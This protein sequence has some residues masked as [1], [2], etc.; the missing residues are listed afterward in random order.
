[1]LDRIQSPDDVKKLDARLLPE[2]CAEIRA[3]LVDHVA[4][5]GGHLASNLGAVELT[6]AVHRVFDTSKDRLVFDVGHQCYIHKMLTGRKDGFASL[7][8]TGGLAG[9][10]KPSESVHDAFIA[11]HA[12]NSISVALGMARAR[13]LEGKDHSVIALIGDGALTGGLAYEAL[14]DAGDSGEKLIVLLNDNG[15]SITEN[16]GGIARH[17]ARQRTRRKY[18][19][20][21]KRY[22]R[23]L[24]AIPGGNWLYRVTHKLKTAAKDA[25]FHCS[26]FEEMGF[27]YV[28]PVDGHDVHK[29]VDAL[30]LAKEFGGPVLVHAITKKGKGYAFSEEYPDEYHGVS[31]FDPKC[32]AGRHNGGD[33]SDVFGRALTG[34]AAGNERIIAV[35][36]A[37]TDGVGLAGFRERFPDRLFD[38][39]IAEAHAAAM[40]AGAA[41][42]GLLPVCAVYSAFLQR[43]YDQLIH[44]TAILGEHVV[45]AVDRAGLVGADGET[46]HGV[47]D[48]AFLRTVP[49]MKL[50]APAS[51]Q[52]LRDMLALAVE[53]LDGPVA[54]RYPRG[55]EGAYRDGGADGSRVL[56]SGR[57]VTI[58]TYGVQVND[59]LAAAEQLEQRQVEAEIVKL[60]FLK[61]LDMEAIRASVAK[62]GRLIVFEETAGGCGVG[63]EIKA[64][65]LDLPSLRWARTLDLGEGFVKHG[66]VQELRAL[67]GLDAAGLVRAVMEELS[68]ER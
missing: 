45:F 32:G 48:V 34:L 41:Q 44:D 66:S 24:R 30:E 67:V 42:E 18:I 46:H 33:F 68:R 43:A 37:M 22:R 19:L 8:K 4:K 14:S 52:E 57:D 54:V 56:R 17:L 40:A 15:M 49:G 10:P 12:S 55:A 27:Q 47:F 38:V 16:V 65:L 60:G 26:M 39:G 50:L 58:V 7:R 5:T 2:L 59:A 21:K 23:L 64:G 62:T 20:F 13:T 63:S 29:L 28:G 31:E 11:G 25:V 61:P 51:Y 6:V 3:F 36:A 9:F 53:G 35:T 1:M